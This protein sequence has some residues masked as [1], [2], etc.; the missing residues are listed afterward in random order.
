MAVFRRANFRWWPKVTAVNPW[1]SLK[2]GKKMD[3]GSLD[4]DPPLLSISN[5]SVKLGAVIVPSSVTA[6]AAGASIID[7]TVIAASTPSRIALSG[8][9]AA[10]REPAGASLGAA[11]EDS[12]LLFLNCLNPILDFADNRPHFTMGR[13]AYFSNQIV[14]IRRIPAT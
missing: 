13:S 4:C 9:L 12:Y 8:L 2:I 1:R 14:K 10:T 11:A 3:S 7:P 5:V 6:R